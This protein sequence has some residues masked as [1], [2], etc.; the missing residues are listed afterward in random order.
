M[1]RMIRS[2]LKLGTPMW[3]F[4]AAATGGLM[5]VRGFELVTQGNRWLERIASDAPPPSS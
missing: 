2:S 1:T 4:F 5:F 3:Q